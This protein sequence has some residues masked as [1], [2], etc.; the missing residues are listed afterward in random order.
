MKQGVVGWTYLVQDER[1]WLSCRRMLTNSCSLFLLNNLKK[2][3]INTV[4]SVFLVV[5]VS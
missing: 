4:T 3:L 1:S 5:N 2:R